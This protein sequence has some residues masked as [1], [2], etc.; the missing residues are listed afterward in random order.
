MECEEVW[1]YGT[2]GNGQ[3]LRLRPTTR[4]LT[5]SLSACCADVLSCVM[6]KT[7]T[8]KT[9]TAF[10]A[11]TECHIDCSEFSNSK[12]FDRSVCDLYMHRNRV[13]N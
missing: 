13:Q 2:V 4:H 6:R 10:P 12:I 3:W 7:K 1:A 9:S 5:L 8:T 11:T